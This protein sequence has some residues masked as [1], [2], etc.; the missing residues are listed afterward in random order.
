MLIDLPVR[1][2]HKYWIT[3][4]NECFLIILGLVLYNGNEESGSGDYVCF[5]LREG[6]PEFSFDVGS[7]PA[8]IQANETLNLNQWHTVRLERNKKSGKNLRQRCLDG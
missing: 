5:G 3:M 6:Y 1:E 8:I 4:N 2:I 7:G